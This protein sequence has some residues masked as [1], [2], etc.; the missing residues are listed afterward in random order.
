MWVCGYV[1][2]KGLLRLALSW[3]SWL[4]EQTR[5]CRVVVWDGAGEVPRP[6][7]FGCEG[8]S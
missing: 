5:L 4:R 2:G 3:F 8:L 1:G 7:E 6:S